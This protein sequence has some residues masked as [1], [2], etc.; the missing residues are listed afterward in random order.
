MWSR[1]NG[2]GIVAVGSFAESGVPDIPPGE[3]FVCE[4]ENV[5]GKV[6]RTGRPARMDSY[7]RAHGSI[8]TRMRHLGIRSRVGAPI[9]VDERVWGP[10]VVGSTRI[11]PLPPDTEERMGEFADLNRQPRQHGWPVLVGQ[12]WSSRGIA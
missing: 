11:E 7:E 9:I 1:E 10:A 5:S 8:A 4:G 2:A 3:S 12:R 6:W